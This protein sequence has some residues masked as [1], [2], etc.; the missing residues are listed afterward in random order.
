[1]R[2]RKTAT[3]PTPPPI[4]ITLVADLQALVTAADQIYHSLTMGLLNPTEVERLEKL[5]TSVMH[6]CHRLLTEQI[7]AAAA[8]TGRP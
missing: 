5:E 2:I 8:R 1:M 7:T 4:P 3:P 6:T